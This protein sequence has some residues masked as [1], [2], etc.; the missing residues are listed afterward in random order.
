MCKRR[1]NGEWFPGATNILIIQIKVS[2]VITGIK[3]S[4]I[5]KKFIYFLLCNY[6]VQRTF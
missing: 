5:P 1:K 6:N 4:E 2:G 3:N